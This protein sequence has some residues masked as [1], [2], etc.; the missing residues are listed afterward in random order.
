MEK[1]DLNETSATNETAP[2]LKFSRERV[3]MLRVTT[4]IKTGETCSDITG[5]GTRYFLR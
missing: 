4:G 1:R 2:K 5:E 3:R